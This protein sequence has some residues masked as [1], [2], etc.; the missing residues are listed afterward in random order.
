MDAQTHKIDFDDIASSAR[1][2]VKGCRLSGD[3]NN[4]KILVVCD[5]MTE[6]M[7]DCIINASNNSLQHMGG[8][9]ADLLTKAGPILQEECTNHIK[10]HGPLKTGDVFASNPGK[11]KCKKVIHAV[12]P[13][14]DG[15]RRNEESLLQKAI[16]NTMKEANQLMMKSIAVPAISSS[17]FGY[18]VKKSVP[19]IVDAC[20]SFAHKSLTEIRF[21]D[22][23]MQTIDLFIETLKSLPNFKLKSELAPKDI[24]IAPMQIKSNE[25]KSTPEV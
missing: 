17:I 24:L 13:R 6:Q 4:L 23:N 19:L 18:P 2:Q 14:Y 12:G 1:S 9:A 21:V 11:L 10:K 15:G 22:I 8:L 7:V 16:L 25:N 5:D 20:L 3:I